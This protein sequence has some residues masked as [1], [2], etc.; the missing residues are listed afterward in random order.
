MSLEVIELEASAP[1]DASI[2]VLHGLGADGDDFVPVAQQWD[3]SAVAKV[4]YLFP[5]APMRPV[6]IN[7]GHVMRAWYDIYGTAAGFSATEDAQGL[8]QSQALI[9][10]LIDREIE[11]GIP[12]SRI[13]LAGFSQGCAMTLMT[14]LRYPQRLAG[15]LAMS[16]YLP[17][18]ATVGAERSQANSD[19]PIFQAHGTHDPVIAIQRASA[20]RDALI[21]L[22]HTVEWHVYPMAHSVCD[23]EIADM[24]RW[25]LRILR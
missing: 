7:G 2:I 1:P 21:G 13:V 10:S 17:L 16:G 25:L 5:T 6:T 19:V 24:Q 3:L 18:A 22:G 8:R 4:R 11:R 12:A 20:S 15:L 14:G 9:G 23:A